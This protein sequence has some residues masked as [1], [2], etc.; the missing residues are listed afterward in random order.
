MGA[1]GVGQQ[2]LVFP[3]WDRSGLFAVE[4]FREEKVRWSEIEREQ[5]H[6]ASG[7][8]EFFHLFHFFHLFAPPRHQELFSLVGSGR[9]F[10]AGEAFMGI[11]IGRWPTTCETANLG[12]R[13]REFWEFFLPPALGKNGLPWWIVGTRGE[14]GISARIGRRAIGE[15]RRVRTGHIGRARNAIERLSIGSGKYMSMCT[16]F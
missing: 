15:R 13:A 8:G 5:G 1:A 11:V 7:R 4:Q 2:F 14:W 12:P 16:L 3:K 6:G 9:W 10:A